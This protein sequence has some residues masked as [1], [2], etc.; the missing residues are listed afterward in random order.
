LRRFGYATRRDNVLRRIAVV[1]VVVMIAF[2]ACGEEDEYPE[3]VIDNFMEGC[4]SQPGATE[5]YCRCSIERIQEEVSFDEFRE[6]EEGLTDAS[7][8]PD[9]LVDAISECLEA[10]SFL[11]RPHLVWVQKKRTG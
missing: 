10:R 5:S 9:R 1:S 2:A 11:L 8:F 3:E 4:T 7:E 6:L